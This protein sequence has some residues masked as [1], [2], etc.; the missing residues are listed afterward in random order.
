MLLAGD[1]EK[2]LLIYDGDCAFCNR[3]LQFGLNHLRWFPAHRPFQK[4]PADA[5]GHSR[6]DFEKS[7]WLIGEKAEYSGHSAAAWILLQQRNPLH[8]FAGFLIQAFSPLS[9]LAYK[10]VATNR[11]KLPGGTPACETDPKA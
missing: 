10:W 3:S 11:H 2:A 7:I 1:R 6:S 5:F 4:L 8:K 9:A